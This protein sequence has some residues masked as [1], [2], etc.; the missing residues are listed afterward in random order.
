[1]RILSGAKVTGFEFGGNS[2]AVTA[3]LTDRGTIETD[4]VVVAAGPWVNALWDMLELPKTVT[5]K[6]GGGEPRTGVPM[7]TYWSLQE[8]T[9]GVDPDLQR[10]N[11]GGPAPVIHVDSDR[12]L[13][14]DVDGLVITAMTIL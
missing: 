1:M 13:H 3:V 8:G 12:P 2:G 14:S 6:D 7:W 10:T 5:V 4:Y 11:D 9:L